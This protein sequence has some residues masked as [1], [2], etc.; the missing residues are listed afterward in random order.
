M[1]RTTVVGL[2]LSLGAGL[3]LLATDKHEPPR[4]AVI[5][6]Q[7]VVLA[8]SL[9]RN[10]VLAGSPSQSASDRA[11]N[12]GRRSLSCDGVVRLAEVTVGVGCG[13]TARIALATRRR[14]AD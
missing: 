7:P 10:L 4:D 3:A 12:D 11:G 9:G 14:A 1:H 5:S 6:A 13:P 8:I 2:A